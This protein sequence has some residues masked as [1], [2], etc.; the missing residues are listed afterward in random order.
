MGL[1]TPTEAERFLRGLDSSETVETSA[2]IASADALLASWCGWPT[3]SGAR[4]PTL[5]EATYVEYVEASRMAPRELR[6]TVPDRS[7]I[8][9]IETDAD[10]DFDAATTL[11]PSTYTSTTLG[12]W[13]KSA[14][15]PL[16]ISERSIRV[17][18]VAGFDPDDVPENV[19]LALLLT[20]RELWPRKVVPGL[21]NGL[22][23]E[24]LGPVFTQEIRTL[25]RRYQ[26]GSGHAV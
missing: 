14:A 13:M 22:E 16:P 10:G 24:Q 7:S 9:S 23:G 25:M 5:E 26:V 3:P 20:M 1:V 21:P 2:L 18:Y 12:V 15:A 6:L 11:D 17:T 8:T 19:R 4:C